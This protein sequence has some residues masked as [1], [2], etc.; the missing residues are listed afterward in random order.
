[1]HKL[2]ISHITGRL[3][4]I[5]HAVIGTPAVNLI[6]IFFDYGIIDI[7]SRVKGLA[8]ETLIDRGLNLCALTTGL[9]PA[10]GLG[11]ESK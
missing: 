2:D 10:M 8:C 5:Q 6:E 3:M 11:I 7:V 9:L 4:G 1:M